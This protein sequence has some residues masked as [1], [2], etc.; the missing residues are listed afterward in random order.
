MTRQ[1]KRTLS[2]T[3]SMF[4]QRTYHEVLMEHKA[5]IVRSTCRVATQT[6]ASSSCRAKTL[7]SSVPCGCSR[8]VGAEGSQD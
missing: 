5:T 8:Q 3:Q 1:S 4:V 6:G 2:F 7:S